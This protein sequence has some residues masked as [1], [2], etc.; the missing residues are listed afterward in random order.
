M[1]ANMASGEVAKEMK[2]MKMKRNEENI[3]VAG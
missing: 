1:A 3:S 2:K